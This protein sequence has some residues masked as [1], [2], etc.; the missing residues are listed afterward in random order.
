MP[1]LQRNIIRRKRLLNLGIRLAVTVVLLLLI[2]HN[3]DL[4][5]SLASVAML[6]PGTVLLALALQLASN[7]VAGLRW[8][9]IMRRIGSRQS[10]LFFLQSYFK[11]AFFNQGLP[12]SIGGDAVR[13]MDCTA[14][15]HTALDG[16]SG[17]FIDRFVGLAGLLLLNI[18]ALLFN[19]T[20]LPARVYFPLL[21]ILGL[22]FAVL[23]A[24]FYVR[25]IPLFMRHR[26]LGFIG[27]LSTRYHQ[28]YAT[29][30][31]VVLQLGLS[32]LIHLL[33]MT[34]FSVLGVSVGLDYPLTTYLVLVPPVVLLTILPISLAGW[35]VREGAM[36]G[37]FLLIG[38]DHA[39]V[40]TFSV[41]YG[42][43]ALASSLPGLAVYL[44]QRDADE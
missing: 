22:L 13:I 19:R 5:E 39:R 15:G 29:P 6:S 31:S 44:I 25:R 11:G 10:A 28:V 12:T 1:A 14:S 3:V 36:I 18:C 35:G 8:Y 2:G 43:L 33:A 38:A 17:V 41:L 37:F 4:E 23:V 26:W 42:L 27:Q 24:L 30:G 21:A 16:F 32:V 34:A 9:L 7:S 20:I 40:L